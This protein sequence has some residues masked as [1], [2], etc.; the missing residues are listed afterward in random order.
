MA[1]SNSKIFAVAVLNSLTRAGTTPDWDS[2]TLKCAL[3]NNSITPDNSVAL[4]AS[5][6]NTGVWAN[7]NEQ[8]SAG[9]WAAGGV[10]LSGVS[11]TQSGTVVTFTASNTASGATA[12]LANV[13]GGLVYDTTTSNM[14][15]TYNYFGGSNGVTS[16]TFTVAWNASGIATFTVT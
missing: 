9:Q 15:L 5:E 14:G 10:A 12:T 11:V 3:Y 1:W 13:Y 7:T 16:G 4:A 8:S 6:Y 2:D